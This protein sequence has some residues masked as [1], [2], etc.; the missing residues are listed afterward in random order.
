MAYFQFENQ[1]RYAP[2]H[3]ASRKQFSDYSTE[4]LVFL[5]SEEGQ[6]HQ[7]GARYHPEKT[8]CRQSSAYPLTS[9]TTVGPRT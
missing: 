5:L 4:F 3:F 1:R 6:I 9:V 8:F 2:R 7:D